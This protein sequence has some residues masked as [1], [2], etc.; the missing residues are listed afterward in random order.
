[1]SDRNADILKKVEQWL[2]FGAE[3]LRLACHGLPIVNINNIL[4]FLESK[5][6]WFLGRL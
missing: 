2:S 4:E 3:D 1:M 5:H 6:E